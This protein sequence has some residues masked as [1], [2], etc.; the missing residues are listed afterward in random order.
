MNHSIISLLNKKW[1]LYLTSLL[2]S[3]TLCSTCQ[4]A[5]CHR[6]PYSRNEH[7]SSHM[8]DLI[9]CDLW[10]PS[11]VKSTLGFTYYVLFIDDYSRFTWLYP[12]KFKFDFFDVFI[13]FQKFV[14]NQHSARIKIFQSDCGTE[15]TNNCFKAH[16]RTSSIHHQL[17][18]PHTPSQNGRA[19]RKNRHVTET[20]LALLFHFHLSPR[21][22]V[23]AFSTAAYIIN[24]LP[25]PLLGGKSPFELLYGSSPNYENFHP[26]SC[27]VYPCLRDYM[28]N[29]LSPRSI[30][31]IFL[32]YNPSYKGFRCLDLTTNRLYIT[33]HA[34]FDETHFL[35]LDSSQAQP[36]SSLHISNFLEPCL[37]HTDLPSSSTAPYSQHVPQS[38]SS[39][40]VICTDPVDE[41]VQA[42]DSLVGPS[43]PHPASSLP[44]I[45]TTTKIIV[46]PSTPAFPMSSHPMLTRAKAGIFKTRHPANLGVL[47]SFGLLPT[48]LVSTEPKGFKSAAKN[49]AWLTAMD[50]E[51]QALQQNRTWVLVP[52]PA[53]TNIVGSKWVFRTKYLP[54]GSIKRLKARLV[55]KGYTQVPGLDYTDTFS[56]IIKATT[57][58]VVLSLVVTNKWPLRQLDVKN[59]FLNG[60]LTE[61][62]YMEQLPGHIDP[63]F[64]HHVCHL[65]KALYS[66]KQAPRAWF[67]RFSSF[68]LTLGFSCSRADTS[69]FVFHQQSGIIYLL[70]YVDDIIITGNNS[71]LLDSFTRKLHS[72][73]ATKDL[74]SLSYFLGLESSPTPDGLFL[75][76]LKYARDIL[77]RAQL[78][79][80]KPVHTPM[81]VS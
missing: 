20:G 34:Q 17:S 55:A 42:I 63:R 57:V 53:N 51:V 81:V 35:S 36:L 31:C 75:S 64:P 65:K 61:H 29:K 48:L 77:T 19:E 38:S 74:G 72:E 18:C 32:G 26:F 49:L 6:L 73:F 56:P 27:R 24:W 46:G 79:D 33:R 70:L 1:H 37:F 45:K 76:Q 22:W 66:L 21:F 71:S 58:C 60:T 4:L 47:G 59:T 40:C 7:R 43:L 15:F 50:E 62:V 14:E 28:P 44:S 25:T 5:K 3:P 30:P 9:H 16:L 69:L 67:Q 2:P 10:G 41:S 52:R 68:L 8:L 13:Q 80:S 54:D 23:D 78:L 39:P 12:L 11:P